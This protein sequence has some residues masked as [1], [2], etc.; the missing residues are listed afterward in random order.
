[1]LCLSNQRHERFAQLI[2]KGET[3]TAAYRATY[4]VEGAS[5]EVGA[6]RLLSGA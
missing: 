3:G 5:A 6:S 1:M 4:G 2:A